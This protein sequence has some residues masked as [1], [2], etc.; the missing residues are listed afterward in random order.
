[1]AVSSSETE[2]SVLLVYWCDFSWGGGVLLS[3]REGTCRLFAHKRLTKGG[4][5]RAPQDP[6]G[7][8]LDL[9]ACSCQV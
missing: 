8:A 1:M 9:F 5:S 3:H 2:K 4:G 6:P 7:Y